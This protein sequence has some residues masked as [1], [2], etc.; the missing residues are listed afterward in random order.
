MNELATTVLA[1]LEQPEFRALAIILASIILAKIVDWLACGVLA[2]LARRSK[3]TLD[4][5][6]IEVLH[7]PIFVSV[8]L[9][10]LYLAHAQF[11]FGDPYDLL[12]AGF[13]KTLALLVW[14]SAILKVSK[15]A[16]S[17]AGEL[18]WVD[19]R[20]V[21]LFENVTK[22]VLIGGAI[23]ALLNLWQ[24]DVKPWLASAGIVGLALGFAAKDSL[25]NIF[26]GLSIIIDAP[27]KIGD[28]INLDGG[29]RGMVTQIGLRSTRI[30]T[31]DDVEVTVPNSIIANSTINN[32]SGGH[33][34]RTRIRVNVGVAYGS[35]VDRV[36]EILLTSALATEGVIKDPVPR[37][38]F[39]EMGDS[40]LIFQI[41]YWI[42]E[43]V[44]RGQTIDAITTMVYKALN[45]ADIEIPFPQRDLHLRSS[46][47]VLTQSTPGG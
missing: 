17:K 33:W 2:R 37:I 31:R 45:A 7:R 13:I 3:T 46:D 11:E 6:I 10:G 9:V 19:G 32:E 12:V 22:I 4:D 24:L 15:Q 34:Q 42:E 26:G 40:A 39:R 29:E 23:Y 36:R 28:F 20:A 5:K 41:Q 16:Y 35:D 27:Y 1:F 14:V 47:V 8:V 21:P 25:G 18:N 44:L 43:P 38:R 30:L